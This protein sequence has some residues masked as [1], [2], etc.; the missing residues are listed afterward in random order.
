M[1][2]VDAG[3]K[4]APPRI[5]AGLA[6]TGKRPSDVTRIVSTHAHPDHGGGAAV[7]VARP[8][9]R[10]PEKHPKE[11][12]MPGM[13]G[14]VADERAGLLAFLAQQRLALRIA[15]HGLTDEQARQAPRRGRSPSAG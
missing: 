13:P 15:A 12:P 3:P 7:L 2:L 1:T 4:P 10:A 9:G 14:P 11:G 5:V 6:A 8:S